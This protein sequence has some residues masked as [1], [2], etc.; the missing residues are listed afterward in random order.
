MAV[1]IK[2]N[3]TT[4]ANVEA[5][6]TATLTCKDK[7][8]KTD[9]IIAAPVIE[10]S[11]TPVEVATAD[12]MATL[13][14]TAEVG[15]IYKYTGETTDAYENGVLYMVEEE[16]GG[17]TVSVTSTNKRVFVYDT[18]PTDYQGTGA[19]GEVVSG[20]TADFKITTG[21]LYIQ[22]PNSM[23]LTS[24]IET[25]G[26]TFDS[27][28]NDYGSFYTSEYTITGDGTISVTY[29]DFD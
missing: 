4:I 19:L 12:E 5:G 29:G 11:A 21:K 26:V 28:S 14:E 23:N 20:G 27:F 10:D 7:K 22:E 6:K 9:I 2:Y 17:Y 24:H 3:D 13:L 15:A 1:E 16:K 18:P 25:G 8:M